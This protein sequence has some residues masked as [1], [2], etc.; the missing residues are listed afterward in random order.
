[1]KFNLKLGESCII[2]HDHL[3]EDFDHLPKKEQDKVLLELGDSYDE[4]AVL[5]AKK[6]KKTGKVKKV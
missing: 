6:K 3:K 2:A 5:S 4:R 1:M